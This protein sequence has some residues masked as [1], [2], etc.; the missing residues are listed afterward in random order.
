MIVSESSLYYNTILMHG[1]E[2]Y[3]ELAFRKTEIENAIYYTLIK[4]HK[5]RIKD[6]LNALYTKTNLTNTVRKFI[7]EYEI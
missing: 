1:P 7:E 6:V 3:M 2:G 5:T 4:D